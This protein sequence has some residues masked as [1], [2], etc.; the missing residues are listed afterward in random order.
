MLE[1]TQAAAG[2][3]ARR[4]W[5]RLGTPLIAVVFAVLAASCAEAPT[6]PNDNGWRLLPGKVEPLS[7]AGFRGGRQCWVY[8]PP[9]YGTSERRYPVLYLND[10]ELA[11]QRGMQVNRICESL[12]RRGEIEPLIVVA[13]ETGGKRFEEYVPL[14]ARSGESYVAAVADT[15]KPEIDRRYRTLTGPE[16]TAIS[17]FSLGGLIS[18]YAGYADSTFGKVGAFSPSYGWTLPSFMYWAEARGRPRHLV[19]YYQDTGYPRDNG[20]RGMESVLVAQGFRHGVDLMSVTVPGAEHVFDA[21]QHRFP[22]MLRF[23]FPPP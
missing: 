21:C 13:I 7:F 19:R 18:A 23:L 17:G 16:N 20:I 8:L 9:G 5:P 12:I 11:F 14:E 1:F 10:G 3:G 22:G 2:R 6:G 15:L 4:L